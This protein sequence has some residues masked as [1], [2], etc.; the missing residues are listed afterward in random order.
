[1]SK[2]KTKTSCPSCGKKATF[3]LTITGSAVPAGTVVP[4]CR[5]S[6]PNYNPQL[7]VEPGQKVGEQIVH[8]KQHLRELCARHDYRIE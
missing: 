2:V 6:Y 4:G 7:P 8:S 5:I 1:M 3:K